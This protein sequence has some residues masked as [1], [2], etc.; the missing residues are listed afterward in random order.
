M[1]DFLHHGQIIVYIGNA[2]FFYIVWELLD[3]K[4]IFRFTF[5]KLKN[6]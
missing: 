2:Y 4:V 3:K 5:K 1:S 6:N